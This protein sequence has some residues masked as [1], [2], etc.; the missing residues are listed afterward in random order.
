MLGQNQTGTAKIEFVVDRSGLAQLP[1][2]LEASDPAFGWA[3]ATWVGA[4]RFNQLTRA[5]QP[6]DLR[7]VVPI[8]FTPPA[9][10]SNGGS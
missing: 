8:K 1:R 7:V 10:N 3:A 6:T 9:T 2:I 5:G 4:M